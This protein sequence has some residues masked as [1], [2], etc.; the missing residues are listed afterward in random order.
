MSKRNK[1]NQNTDANASG[2]E[3]LENLKEETEMTEKK[4]FLSGAKE[5]IG[6]LP[7]PVKIV[8]GVV[9]GAGAAVGT[10][11]A[12]ISK[13]K[14]DKEDSYIDCD[15]DSYEESDAAPSEDDTPAEEE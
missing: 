10:A 15:N 11:F 7:K 8:G 13:I 4:G 9:I 14:S 3:V 6:G 2:V 5:F 1:K 12:V